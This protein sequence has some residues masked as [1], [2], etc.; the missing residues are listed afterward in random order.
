VA[1]ASRAPG[2]APADNVGVT[3]TAESDAG[4]SDSPRKRELLDAAYAYALTNGLADLSLRPLARSIG[5]S[6]RVL[7][8][9]F[10]SKDGL[11]RALL[12]R[13]RQ[14]ELEVLAAV[15]AGQPEAGL[16]ATGRD[17]WEWLAAPAHRALLTLWLE[18]YARSL[19][20]EAGPWERFAVETVHDWLALLAASQPDSDPRTTAGDADRTLLLAVLRGALLDL[21]AT[22]DAERVTAAV[23]RYL[24]TLTA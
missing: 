16:A 10:G 19:L 4:R 9:L 17:V 24:A 23:D 2:R 8:F 7:L 14:D 15:R 22:G 12:A 6:P 21:L 20:G 11:T 3:S 1:L 13:A 18:G 5:T